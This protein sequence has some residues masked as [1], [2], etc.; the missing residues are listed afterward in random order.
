MEAPLNLSDIDLVWSDP[1]LLL[2][3]KMSF[4]ILLTTY[5]IIVLLTGTFLTGVLIHYEKHEGDPMKR[6]LGNQVLNLHRHDC[7]IASMVLV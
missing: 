2:E 5:A 3:D 4:K 7:N 1:Y 6:G